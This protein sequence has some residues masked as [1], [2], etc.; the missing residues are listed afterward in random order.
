MTEHQ[1]ALERPKMVRK[2]TISNKAILNHFKY[3][4]ALEDRLLT[5]TRETLTLAEASKLIGHPIRGLA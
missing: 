5:A 4:N 2:A 1:I 3:R